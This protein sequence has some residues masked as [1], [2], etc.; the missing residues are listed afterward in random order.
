MLAT[1]MDHIWV[2][3]IVFLTQMCVC[4]PYDRSLELRL[5]VVHNVLQD[6]PQRNWD[7]QKDKN[8]SYEPGFAMSANLQTQSQQLCISC[9]SGATTETGGRC[10]D[11]YLVLLQLPDTEWQHS[12]QKETVK[13]QNQRADP[14]SPL[15]PRTWHDGSRILRVNYRYTLKP[16]QLEMNTY[17]HIVLKRIQPP[18][19][20]VKFWFKIGLKNP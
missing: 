15:C 4:P 12:H 16:T 20:T 2:F 19:D 18:Q 7:G 6:P 10:T 11:A 8:S 13:N 3:N 9:S 14:P 17:I 1:E 5:S